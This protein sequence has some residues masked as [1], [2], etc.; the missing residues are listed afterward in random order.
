MFSFVATLTGLKFYEHI[1]HEE[2]FKNGVENNHEKL[3]YGIGM[4][5]VGLI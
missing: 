1:S 2:E 4:F 3:N 5:Q